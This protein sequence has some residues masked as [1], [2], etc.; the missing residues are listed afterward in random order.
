MIKNGSAIGID[1]TLV[2]SEII[3]VIPYCIFWK[4]NRLVFQGCNLQ[5]AQQFGYNDVKDIIGKTDDDF[6]WSKNELK[7]KY[8]ADDLYVIDTGNSLLN[9]EEEQIQ[10]NGSIETLLVS[11]VPIKNRSGEIIG[12][13]GTYN[14]ITHLKNIENSLRREKEKAEAASRAKTEFLGSISH[15]MKSPLVGIV[16]SADIVAYD[17]NMPEKARYFSTVISDSGKQLESFFTSCL[18]LSKMEME[19][20][21][22][23]SSVFSIKKLLDDVHS[24][25]LPKA[26]SS[27]LSLQVEYDETLPQSVEGHRDSLYRVLLNLVGN[28][29][30]FTEKGSITLRALPGEPIDNQNVNVIFEVQDTGVGIP[31]DKHKVIFEKLRRLTPSYE[32][33][34]EG[35]GIGLYIV[36]QYVKR[37]GG[38]IEVKSKIGDGSTFIVKVPLKISKHQSKME[39]FPETENQP[40]NTEKF[41]KKVTQFDNIKS[42]SADGQKSTDTLT[43]VLVVED[44]DIIQLVTKT[45]LHEAG[46]DVDIASSG[47]EALAMFEP[48]KYGLIYMDIGL[49]KMNG[50]ET[51]KAI[52]EKEKSLMSSVHIPIIALTG[53]GAVDVKKFCGEAGMQGILSKPLSREQAET[54]WQLYGQHKEVA[55]RGLTIL[56]NGDSVIPEQ[57][58]LD[59]DLT[60]QR[61]GSKEVARQMIADFIQ[62]LETQFL[63]KFKTDVEKNAR[64]SLRFQLHQQLG[65]VAYVE[66]PLL[67][68]ALLSAQKSVKSDEALTPVLYQELEKAVIQLG[69]C[70]KKIAS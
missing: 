20:W 8:N 13:L 65:S 52:R 55:V 67:R 37:M 25:Y 58:I 30:K 7:E 11:K 23:R 68:E 59:I 1:D 61:M 39:V 49:P 18:D 28:A 32:S 66:A 47:E 54:V 22:S 46:F 42:F 26:M 16:S 2:L 24:L 29:L 9:I 64:E 45:L 21:A 60:I 44:T 57:D 62:S 70:Y 50:Y 3:S 51:A 12:I 40:I 56:E 14:N 48:G 15:D 33:K 43:R 4:N 36:D 31:E 41:D 19:E 27:H 53:H 69:E 6:P 38:S 35:S 17:Q 34:I 63:P 5:F 10:M